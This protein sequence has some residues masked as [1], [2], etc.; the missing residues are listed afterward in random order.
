[1]PL[2]RSGASAGDG[3]TLFQSS[4]VFKKVTGENFQFTALVMARTGTLATQPVRRRQSYDLSDDNLR[5]R[6]KRVKM[7]VVAPGAMV[8]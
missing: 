6:Q 8:H 2:S 4:R 7:G 1:M 5:F 3:P